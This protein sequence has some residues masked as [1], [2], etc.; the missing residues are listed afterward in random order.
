MRLEDKQKRKRCIATLTIVGLVAIAGLAQAATLTRTEGEDRSAQGS[1][2]GGSPGNV[3][4]TGASAGA[5]LSM[6]SEAGS[7]CWADVSAV[8]PG[9]NS[10]LVLRTYQ[11]SPAGANDCIQFEVDYVEIDPITHQE[12]PYH[13][14]TTE[15]ANCGTGFKRVEVL[16]VGVAAPA[17]F[18]ASE[19]A[20]GFRFKAVRQTGNESIPIGLDYIEYVTGK[21]TREAETQNRDAGSCVT[22]GSTS[23]TLTGLGC[24]A[25]WDFNIPANAVK[26]EVS[27]RVPGAC[28]GV[29]T[30]TLTEKVDGQVIGSNVV[31]TGCNFS[32]SSFTDTTAHDQNHTARLELTAGT[33][34][35]EIDLIRWVHWVV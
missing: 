23:I 16:Q 24:Y 20:H 29:D 4:V 25:E 15:S 8:N 9:D 6:P 3:T 17:V 21:S 10:V 33:G 34:S 12:V 18:S 7:S 1:C 2:D 35:V 26:L 22:T 27:A 13:R 11:P 19:V 28:T 14:G 32:I 30:A 5:V 31:A